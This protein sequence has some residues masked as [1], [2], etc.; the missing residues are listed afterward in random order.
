MIERRRRRSTQAHE[1]VSHYLEAFR[2]KS[3]LDAVALTTNDGLLIGGAGPGVDL[4]WMGALGAASTNPSLSWE[5]RT[6][7]VESLNVHDF[8]LRLTVAGGKAKA[9]A[10]TDGLERILPLG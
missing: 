8:D 10:L 5:A 7:H 4:E 6:L 1:A 3:G 9:R 2:E